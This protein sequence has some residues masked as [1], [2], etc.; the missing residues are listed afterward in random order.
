MLEDSL[1]MLYPGTVEVI[2]SAQAA[3]WS[4]WESK[5]CVRGF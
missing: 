1:N 5:I 2:N 4:T 3:M